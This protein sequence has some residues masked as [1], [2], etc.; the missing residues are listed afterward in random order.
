LHDA[1][2]LAGALVRKMKMTKYGLAD[3]T[4]A[5]M[6]NFLTSFTVFVSIVAAYVI[7][8][9]TAGKK[10]S[11]PQEYVVNTCFFM[12][13]GAIGLLSVLIF[14]VFLRRAQTLGESEVAGPATLGFTWVVAMRVRSS[15]S[16]PDAVKQNIRIVDINEFN[17]DGPVKKRPEVDP[18]LGPIPKS[19]Q[20][21]KEALIDLSV[22][23]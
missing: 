11:K 23:S 13:S 8:A 19:T 7:A 3:W 16:G 21:T 15:R 5:A 9:F 17:Q 4:S 12:A 6:S 18:Q 22:D 1:W 2:V 20:G 10:L 14:Q